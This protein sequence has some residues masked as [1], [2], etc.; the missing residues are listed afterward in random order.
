MNHLNAQYLGQIKCTL[1]S[2]V[3]RMLN[4]SIEE[5]DEKEVKSLNLRKWK[6][7]FIISKKRPRFVEANT[8]L[9]SKKKPVVLMRFT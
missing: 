3:Y 8:T 9:K 4:V 2:M 7:D 5:V 6:M 1:D